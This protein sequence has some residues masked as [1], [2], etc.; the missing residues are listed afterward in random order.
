MSRLIVFTSLILG[1]LII[2]NFR[3]YKN[4]KVDNRPFN[5]EATK[6]ANFKKKAEIDSLLHPK[7]KEVLVAKVAEG[8]LVELTTDQ[9]KN[10]NALYKKCIACHGKRGEGKKAQKAPA[11]GG[12]FDWYITKQI[13]DM[14]T[15]ERINKVM[16]PYIKKLSQQDVKDLSAY[17]SK[18]PHMGRK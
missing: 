8:P 17:I 16:N 14:K 15:G 7:E 13:M 6:A 9:L 10:G 1:V 12:Q 11:V 3:D 18:L 2:L 5:F 4:I